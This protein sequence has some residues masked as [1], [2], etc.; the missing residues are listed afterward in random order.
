MSRIRSSLQ[1]LG[2][3]IA[4]AGCG[5][6]ILFGAAQFTGAACPATQCDLHCKDQTEGPPCYNI[7]NRV[8]TCTQKDEM[9]TACGCKPYNNNKSCYCQ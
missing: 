5:L 4:V 8:N 6:A 3:A 1:S 7:L 9:C 2:K